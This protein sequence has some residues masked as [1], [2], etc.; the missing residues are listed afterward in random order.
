MNYSSKSSHVISYYVF[1][2]QIFLHI[3]LFLKADLL[4]ISN[5]IKYLLKPGHYRFVRTRDVSVFITT[6]SVFY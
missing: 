5:L 3:S 1:L 2:L 6:K 4:Y